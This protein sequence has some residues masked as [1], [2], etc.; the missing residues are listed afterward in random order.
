MP[1]AL[2]FTTKAIHRPNFLAFF[3]KGAGGA[4]LRQFAFLGGFPPLKFG[5]KTTEKL[6]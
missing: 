2:L 6:A 1:A 3:Q 4:P 5:P